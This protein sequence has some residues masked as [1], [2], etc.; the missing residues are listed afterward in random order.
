LSV[1]ELV[2]DYLN[3]RVSRRGFAKHMAGWGFS[4]AAVG[5]ILDSLGALVDVEAAAEAA[6]R[7]AGVVEG[8]ALLVAQLR[9]AGVQFVFNCNGSGSSPVFDALVDRTD[10][11]VIAVPQ[12]GQLIAVAQG[13]ALA[14][15]RV[16]F[17]MSDSAGFPNT[18]NNMFNAWRDRTPLVIGSCASPP[19]CRAVARRCRSGRLPRSRDQLHA[20]AMECRS[21][22]PHP[23]ITRR[24]PD[25]VDAA[26]RSVALFFP[27]DVLAASVAPRSSITSGSC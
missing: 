25:R 7:D 20:L 3:R 14:S 4:V 10:V 2:D 22:R 21:R 17:T 23:E 19:R 18:L 5:S 8:T 6:E 27:D 11:H 12:E 26:R 13:Y 24:A 15:G 1:R 9:A 16:A